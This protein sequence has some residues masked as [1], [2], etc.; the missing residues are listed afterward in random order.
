MTSQ[1]NRKTQKIEELDMTIEFLHRNSLDY[2]LDCNTIEPEP[3]ILMRGLNGQHIGLEL[4]RSIKNNGEAEMKVA[5][6]KNLFLERIPKCFYDK[7]GYHI[8]GNLYFNV[9]KLNFSKKEINKHLDP[10]VDYIHKKIPF[11]IG[12]RIGVHISNQ[13]DYDTGGY[14]MPEFVSNA[15]IVKVPDESGALLT[16]GITGPEEITKDRIQSIIDKKEPKVSAYRKSCQE[17]WLL[18]YEYRYAATWLNKTE[19]IQD[20]KFQSSFDRV[21]YMT[22]W[23]KKCYELDIGNK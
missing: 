13:F 4:T 1:A 18:I 12:Y 16:G 19:L 22:L 8:S 6:M 5:G 7:Y 15:R 14:P 20:M 23:K 10:I 2:S 3:D 9:G 17:V 11:D 21:F